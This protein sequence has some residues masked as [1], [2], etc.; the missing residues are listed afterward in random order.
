M[1]LSDLNSSASSSNTNFIED[2][3]A[4][5]ILAYLLSGDLSPSI[6]RVICDE[7]NTFDV[8]DSRLTELKFLFRNSSAFNEKNLDSYYLP[9]VLK[10]TI[11]EDLYGNN[12][13]SCIKNEDIPLERRKL[14]ISLCLSSDALETFKVLEAAIPLKLKEYVIDTKISSVDGIVASLQ[15]DDISDDIKTKIVNRKVDINNVFPVTKR[16]VFKWC[17]FVLGIKS[18]EISDYIDELTSDNIIDFIT[19]GN[20]LRD[21]SS[22]VIKTKESILEKGIDKA[23]KIQLIKMLRN[24]NDE[25]LSA[26][27]VNRRED[28]VLEIVR[29][30]EPRT[31]LN[32]LNLS[33]LPNDI[34]DFILEMHINTIHNEIKKHAIV[35][36]NRRYL[37]LS[38]SLPDFLKREIF[39]EYKE[40]FIKDIEALSSDQ[41]IDEILYA[42]YGEL[43]LGLLIDVGINKDNIFKLLSQYDLNSNIAYMT[44]DRKKD[45]L[46][47][48]ILGLDTKS[49]L[50]LSELSFSNE[51]KNRI[52]DSCSD[53]VASKIQALSRESLLGY[54][55]NES[56][57][58]SVKRR[59]MEHF[60]IY[61]VDLQNCL[62]ILDL[63]NASLL[64]D[65]YSDIKDLISMAGIDFQ[66][67]LKY[68]TGSQKYKD[69]LV[70]LTSV[71]DNG[72]SNDFIRVK[73]Y[74]FNE[75]VKSGSE[76]KADAISYFLE[77]VGN[78]YKYNNLLL[79]L[80]N[81]NRHL[82]DKEKLD[83]QFLF[84]V[85]SSFCDFVPKRLEDIPLY[86]KKIYE[87][88]RYNIQNG[89]TID[90]AKNIFNQYLFLGEDKL[91]SYIGGT[92]GVMSLKK[93]NSNSK[94]IV[95]AADE[96]LLYSK[97]MEMVNDTN[98]LS[99][100][101]E[102]LDFIFSDVEFIDTF[103]NLFLQF[104]EK[105][106]R[107]Y[108]A[109]CINHLTS[110]AKAKSLPDTFRADL[111]SEYGG[112]VYDFS[113][114]NYV[115]FGH[116]LSPNED[117]EKRLC[118][119]TSGKSNFISV[120][121]ISYLGQK[122]YYD[123]SYTILLFDKIHRGSFKCGSIKN[124]GTNHKL[125]INSPDI[126]DINRTQ[127]DI[128]ETS[129]ASEC[130]SEVLLLAEGLSPCGLA[131]PGGRKPSETELEY[132]RKY[133]LPF[134]ITQGVDMSID[135]PKHIF[136]NNGCRIDVKDGDFKI[137]NDIME[138][139]GP[140]S[141]L[142]KE[143]SVYT[144]REVAVFTDCHSMYEPTLAVLEDIRRN[145]ITEIYSL[146]DNVGGG[147]NPREVVELL[148]EY[149]V[150]SIAGNSEYYCTLGV[151]PFPYLSS[152]RI[153]GNSW[154][155]EQLGEK[156]VKDFKLFKPSID[157]TIGGKKL[158]LCHFVNDI[159]WDFRA[160][161]VFGYLSGGNDSCQFLYT[162]SAEAKEEIAENSVLD[163][164]DMRGYVAAKEEPIFGGKRVTDY[165][166]ILQGH[167]HFDLKDKLECTDIY[168]LRAVGMGYGNDNTDTACYYVLREKKDGSF[169]L[170][171]RTVP[172]NK[173]SLLSSI[174]SSS[175]PGK[176][177]ILKYVSDDKK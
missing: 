11:I 104:D 98:N 100:L 81:S 79:G 20:V 76:V 83:I 7:V 49:L 42:K 1:G 165:D 119:K 61:E 135:S 167:A 59:I 30:L 121:P 123:N 23:S 141:K 62:E 75:C 56:V 13:L 137:L 84:N 113:D 37:C 149:G 38:S 133:N 126:F 125:K 106:R 162:N 58:F 39:E 130:N 112:E 108:E 41:V 93:N 115:L 48:Y 55:R 3:S 101:T 87:N 177:Y 44:I 10:R 80:T 5:L 142:N 53:A 102:A 16:L 40:D 63:N 57:L 67:F 111:S 73:D 103:Q 168:T 155:C 120:S 15:D 26:L 158:A 82:S 147:P 97:I 176:E 86:K 8:S 71:V 169:D 35:L 51:F 157:L 21:L 43:M 139:L 161:S 117:F 2:F 163:S 138:I 25:E 171:K 151:E 78:F 134:I 150:V 89:L 156:A 17:G 96:I 66:S 70:I 94:D 24:Y 22:K 77:I 19:N 127:R 27:V 118:G 28:S 34:K 54:L 159:R 175:E 116:V 154:T 85:D 144:G 124:M 36:P 107:L 173:Y 46:E 6:K 166:A 18:K 29:N 148:D 60:G 174:N 95:R 72:Q 136:E 68:G 131:L 74:F 132:H 170:D 90:E 109:D 114:K 65:K 122:Y 140:N 47:Q 143:D 91:L 129:S 152:D 52:L 99:G 32:W 14:I 4:E 64:I 45:V 88:I 31:I 145:G 153:A 164:S 160:H 110:L 128:L 92:A 172:F 9:D 69:W 50:S 12:I 105:V 33:N 146:G